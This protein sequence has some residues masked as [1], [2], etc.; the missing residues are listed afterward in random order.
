MQKKANKHYKPKPT[1]VVYLNLDKEEIK[2]SD[3]VALLE[4]KGSDTRQRS[5]KIFILWR[6]KLL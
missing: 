1:V 6:D 4:A 2:E 3:V 5:K